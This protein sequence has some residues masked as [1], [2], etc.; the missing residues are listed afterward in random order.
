MNRNPRGE[1]DIVYDA[2]GAR[3][4]TMH[5]YFRWVPSH[6]GY[7]DRMLVVMGM[8]TKSV[9]QGI[10][11]YLEVGILM[12]ILV[13]ALFIFW[14]L[15]FAQQLGHLWLKKYRAEHLEAQAAQAAAEL[16]ELQ[17]DGGE[18]RKNPS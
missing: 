12:L 3:P 10:T 14:N 13:A 11:R 17:G 18:D 16:E 9:D 8:S 7:N 4:Y 15:A 5:V 1:L 2:P 6:K